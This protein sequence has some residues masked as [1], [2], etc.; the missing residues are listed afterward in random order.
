MSDSQLRSRLIRLAHTNPDLRPD[1][2][3]LLRTAQPWSAVLSESIRNLKGYVES[4]EAL[5]E[6]SD[7]QLLK[8]IDKTLERVLEVKEIARDSRMTYR[9]AGRMVRVYEVIYD[10][11][12]P[13]PA[14]DGTFIFRTRNKKVAEDF[15]R[16]HTAWG[17]PTEATS[18]EVPAQLAS[19]WGV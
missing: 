10:G 9:R 14:G 19:R 4:M 2:L 7:S 16:E 6:S 18:A 5:A 11:E 3:P 13:G 12:G 1:L 15:A 17:R 8:V